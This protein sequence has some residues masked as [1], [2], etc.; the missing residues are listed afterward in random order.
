MIFSLFFVSESFLCAYTFSL[1][2]LITSFIQNSRFAPLI[3]WH[4]LFTT[5]LSLIV[6]NLVDVVHQVP[7][8]PCYTAYLDCSLKTM[9]LSLAGDCRL[10]F[11]PLVLSFP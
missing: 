3:A 11:S 7:A 9:Y 5:D 2:K 10:R 1:H 6:M 4:L 8:S